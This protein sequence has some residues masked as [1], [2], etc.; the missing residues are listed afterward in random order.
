M[1]ESS[2]E[3]QDTSNNEQAST[4]TTEANSNEEVTTD[5]FNES[6]STP[7]QEPPQETESTETSPSP[8]KEPSQSFELNLDGEK[9]P[10]S[11][12]Q[13]QALAQQAIEYQKPHQEMQEQLDLFQ[14]FFKELTENPL[15]AL[16]KL[17]MDPRELSQ[18][19]LSEQERL[20]NMSDDEKHLMSTESEN[21]R[22]RRELTE[23][24]QIEEEKAREAEEMQEQQEFEEK[25]RSYRNAIA[26][27]LEGSNLPDSPET[28]RRFCWLLDQAQSEGVNVDTKD[29]IPLVEETY[30]EDINSLVSDM[31]GE[32]LFKFLGEEVSTKLREYDLS[33]LG[34]E[35]DE[36][37]Q[38]P[39]NYDESE[40][41]GKKTW[42]SPQDYQKQIASLLK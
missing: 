41:P 3:S 27:A 39:S 13:I 17:E 29:L 26:D 2:N 1:Y 6:S 4:D 12:E 35:Q 8:S 34:H 15:S 33:K 18:N 10:A 16:E 20:A 25:D 21:E 42:I 11:I 30:K 37:S 31:S 23:Y 32:Q 40:K 28:V 19:Y 36:P 7:E 38:T 24:R 5:D 9:I 14:N 22:L